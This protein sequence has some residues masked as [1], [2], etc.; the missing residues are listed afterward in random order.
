MDLPKD[1]FTIR[2]KIRFGQSDPAGIVFF[3]EFFRMFNDLFE[4]WVRIGLDIDFAAQFRDHQRMFPLVHVTTDF[5][6]ARMMGQTMDLTLILTDL[7][8]SSIHYTIIGHDD[9]VEIVR[10]ECVTCIASKKLQKSVPLPDDIRGKMER[11]LEL[12][13]ASPS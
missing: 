8:R 13:A 1:A 5:K 12:C 11:Y 10:A 4:D 3:P 6:K 9:G 7:G 2:R